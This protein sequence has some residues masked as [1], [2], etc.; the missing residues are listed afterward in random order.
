MEL[1]DPVDPSETFDYDP[2]FDRFQELT[3]EL[4]S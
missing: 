1:E 4:V 3:E 2:R